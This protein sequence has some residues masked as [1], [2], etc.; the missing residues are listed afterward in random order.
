MAE[1]ILDLRA[2]TSMNLSASLRYAGEA[3]SRD[4]A[5]ALSVC[6]YPLSS[7]GIWPFRRQM[8]QV[9]VKIRGS[10]PAAS[11][12]SEAIKRG[13]LEYNRSNELEGYGN[14]G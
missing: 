3:L 6:E 8:V 13:V 14:H 10:L 9:I 11:R 2:P 7:R 1:I 4:H 5:V 12:V